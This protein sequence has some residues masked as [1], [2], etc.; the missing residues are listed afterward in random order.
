MLGR[1]RD[2]FAECPA[3]DNEAMKYRHC[4]ANSTCNDQGCGGDAGSGW[5][6]RKY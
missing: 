5:R 1:Y 4:F 3:P 6:D 2:L